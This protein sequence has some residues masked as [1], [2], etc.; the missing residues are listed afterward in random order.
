M[1]HHFIVFFHF[2]SILLAISDS[3]IT[4]GADIAAQAGQEK[5][6]AGIEQVEPDFDAHLHYQSAITN[7]FWRFRAAG[8]QPLFDLIGQIRLSLRSSE[9]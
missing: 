2:L 5:L 1:V 8:I 9:F 7:L 6:L 3:K 4:I